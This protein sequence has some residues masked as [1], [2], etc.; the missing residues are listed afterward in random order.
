[1]DAVRDILT[2]VD[3]KEL[4]HI[5]ESVIERV[6]RNRVSRSGTVDGYVTAAVDGVE[7]FCSTR[8]KQTDV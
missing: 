1:M 6:L 4:G 8:K 2:L 3:P 7:L 5:Q